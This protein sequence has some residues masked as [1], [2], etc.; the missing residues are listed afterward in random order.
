MVLAYIHFTIELKEKA[1][2]QH[3]QTLTTSIMHAVE[4]ETHI[5]KMPT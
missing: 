5:E 2:A 4:M 3:T 1:T